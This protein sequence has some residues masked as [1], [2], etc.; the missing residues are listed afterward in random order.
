MRDFERIAV[1]G[2]LFESRMTKLVIDIGKH[3]D[4]YHQNAIFQQLPVVSYDLNGSK[5][6][7][8]EG[9]IE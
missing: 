9:K 5:Q 4:K 6:S 8:R 7:N 1:P 2:I 3:I